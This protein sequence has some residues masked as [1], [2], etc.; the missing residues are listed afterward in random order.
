M[1][2][3]RKMNGLG[4]DFVVVDARAEPVDLG[5]D[6]IAALADRESGIGFDQYIVIAPAEGEAAAARMRIFNA[7]GGEVEACGNAARCVA[8]LLLEE[9]GTDVVEIESAGGAMAAHRE[10]DLIAVD[11]G[12][13]RF[14]AA[15]I[16]LAAGA[17]DADAL[18]VPGFTHLGLAACANVG[19]PHAV[20]FVPDVD[21]V[22][23]ERD[24]AALERH[25][26]FP[27]RA[28]ISFAEVLGPDRIRARV[29]ERGVGATRACGTA[30][31]AIGALAARLGHTGERVTVE[32]PGGPLQI[33]VTGGRIV[34][35]GPYALDFL[36]TI[37]A[38]GFTVAPNAPAA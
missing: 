22:N 36:G 19:N 17:G 11:M 35:S 6:R 18:V 26:I 9:T 34:M 30:A 5:R 37:E 24:G 28:N 8:G 29:W 31:C 14:E 1:I 32:L 15:D 33:D 10:G 2:P 38:D 21:A 4:N 20:F 16:P 7:D 3:F 27:Q 13:P 12:V 25:P 23:L